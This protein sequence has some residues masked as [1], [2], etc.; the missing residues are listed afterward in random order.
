MPPETTRAPR[1]GERLGHAPG[2]SR[3]SGAGRSRN[4]SSAASLKAT[5]LPAMTC[6]SGP[7][8]DARED[9]PVDRGGQGAIGVAVLDGREGRPGRGRVGS[10]RRLK[11]I[12]PRGPRRVLWVVVVTRSACGNGL[13]W[14]SAATR[15]AMWA[16]SMNSIAPTS[17]G[18]RGHPL[19]VPDPRVGAGAADD[20]LRADFLRLGLHRVVVDALGVLADAVGM[21]LVQ[22]AARS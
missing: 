20:Q 19:E 13:G 7:P 2:R 1:L 4:G 15:P 17:C 8:C 6:I 5:A 16:M 12:P 22:P 11:I 3:S 10:E 21:D 14:T 9:V 18:D